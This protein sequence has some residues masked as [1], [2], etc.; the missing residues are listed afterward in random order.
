VAGAKRICCSVSFS[1][2]AC[3]FPPPRI[4]KSPPLDASPPVSPP[5]RH[6]LAIRRRCACGRGRIP[7]M[8]PAEMR[9]MRRGEPS[10]AC[11]GSG[12]AR[13]PQVLDLNLAHGL[14]T[15]LV[16]HADRGAVTNHLHRA[17]TVARTATPHR[18]GCIPPS[19]PVV[20]TH[21]SREIPCFR[22][23]HD[24]KERP[25]HKIKQMPRH[26]YFARPS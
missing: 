21:S 11:G 20:L 17:S 25:S 1:A 8:C 4:P 16:P 22:P 5:S 13:R 3:L 19:F 24:P 14:K 10:Q 2:A 26:A 23:Q 12:K 7:G 6:A 18:A 9:A 15:R